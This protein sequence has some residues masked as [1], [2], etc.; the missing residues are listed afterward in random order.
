MEYGR[1]DVKKAMLPAIST[2]GRRLPIH[3]TVF[4]RNMY[5]MMSSF[6]SGLRWRTGDVAAPLF[7]DISCTLTTLSIPLASAEPGD[8]VAGQARQA[9]RCALKLTEARAS[10]TDTSPGEVSPGTPGPARSQPAGRPPRLPSWIGG[11]RGSGRFRPAGSV[12][13]S[14]GMRCLSR[15][16]RPSR[17]GRC[18]AAPALIKVTVSCRLRH[19]RRAAEVPLDHRRPRLRRGHRLQVSGRPE[20]AGRARARRRQRVLRQRRRR[21]SRRGAHP[22]RAE[23]GSCSAAASRKQR[24]AGPRPV[25]LPRADR[26]PRGPGRGWLVPGSC[27]RSG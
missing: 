15:S 5:E 1:G 3:P 13:G 26:R 6:S 20:R 16:A 18:P 10:G 4:R 25:Q 9:C 12:T 17:S 11:R 2:I 7:S 24:A 21:D 19:R 27:S 23:P 8:A 14:S 22:A